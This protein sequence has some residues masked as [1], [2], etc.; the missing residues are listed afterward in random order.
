MSFTEQIRNFDQTRAEKE[1]RAKIQESIKRNLRESIKFNSVKKVSGIKFGYVDT[2]KEAKH[3]ESKLGAKFGKAKFGKP[4]VAR[5]RET[6]VT[7]P[8]VTG[9]GKGKWFEL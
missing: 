4:K 8:I 2:S 3:L 9:K 7:S 1:E 6:E 5:Y